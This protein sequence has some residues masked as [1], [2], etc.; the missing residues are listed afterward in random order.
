MQIPSGMLL[1]RT[2]TKLHLLWKNFLF[3]NVC[4]TWC[5]L[6]RIIR[7]FPTK[8]HKSAKKMQGLQKKYRGSKKKMKLLILLCFLLWTFVPGYFWFLLGFCRDLWGFYLDWE[9]FYFLDLIFPWDRLFL[10]FCHFCFFFGRQVACFSYSQNF[11]KIFINIQFKKVKFAKIEEGKKD[12][13]PPNRPLRPVTTP[14]REGGGGRPLCD[15]EEIKSQ[16]IK[17]HKT[18]PCLRL[19]VSLLAFL[20]TPGE[21]GIWDQNQSL[22]P[23]SQSVTQSQSPAHLCI[24]DVVWCLSCP[25]VTSRLWCFISLCENVRVCPDFFGFTH[26]TNDLV[27]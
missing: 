11:H 3:G 9:R 27:K 7:I 19:Q 8:W 25:L 4:T 14:Q 21:E 24:L 22:T 6:W 23:K 10:N 17:Q 5:I 13:K 1:E 12:R 2:Q 18:L 20:I 15:P 16:W 26:H